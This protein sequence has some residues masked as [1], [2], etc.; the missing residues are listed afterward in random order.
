MSKP[1]P[2]QARLQQ[3]VILKWLHYIYDFLC[4]LRGMLNITKS[5]PGH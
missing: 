4:P 1:Y 2:D 5:T 3:M